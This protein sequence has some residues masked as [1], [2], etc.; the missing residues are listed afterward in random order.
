ME[1]FRNL[2]KP[3]R[4]FKWKIQLQDIFVTLWYSPTAKECLAVSDSLN[5]TKY[6]VLGCPCLIIATDH[7]PLVQILGNKNVCDPRLLRLKEKTLSF[8]YG[9]IPIAGNNHLGTNSMSRLFPKSPTSKLFLSQQ[10]CQ[11]RSHVSPSSN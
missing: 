4:K 7:K 8:N 5:R 6:Y 9:I 11:Q 1:P 10:H 3:S 2:I